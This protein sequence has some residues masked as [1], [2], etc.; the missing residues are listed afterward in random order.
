LRHRCG[1]AHALMGVARWLPGPYSRAI[2]R[3][4]DN[5]GPC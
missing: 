4:R 2:R 1:G 3:K 5:P